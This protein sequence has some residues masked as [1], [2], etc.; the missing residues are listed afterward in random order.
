MCGRL[1]NCCLHVGF[2]PYQSSQSVKVKAQG[3]DTLHY[4]LISALT[5]GSWA[6]RL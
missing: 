3:K 1:A 2:G 5:P 4:R 6:T